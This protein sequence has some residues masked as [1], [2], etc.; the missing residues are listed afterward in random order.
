[1]EKIKRKA[2]RIFELVKALLRRQQTEFIDMMSI[3][4]SMRAEAAIEPV[5]LLFG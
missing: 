2:Q 4:L 3:S 5:S 1:M